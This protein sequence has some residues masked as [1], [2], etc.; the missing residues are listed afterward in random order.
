MVSFYVYFVFTFQELMHDIKVMSYMR[1]CSDGQRSSSTLSTLLTILW[2]NA[3]ETTLIDRPSFYLECRFTTSH[4][5]VSALG[6]KSSLGWDGK[7]FWTCCPTVTS[8]D[9]SENG[10][11]MR[12]RLRSPY[13]TIRLFNVEPS[14]SYSTALLIGLA[15]FRNILPGVAAVFLFSAPCW[16]CW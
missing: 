13:K 15:R 14:S 5:T 11:R 1:R 8:F 7:R 3:V 2:I 10:S 6:N 12:S 16:R 9:D 4:V